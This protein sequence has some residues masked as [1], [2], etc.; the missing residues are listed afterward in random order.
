MRHYTELRTKLPAAVTAAIVVADLLVKSPVNR[1]QIVRE[2]N[3]AHSARTVYARIDY[4]RVKFV[5]VV[6]V[7]GQRALTRLEISANA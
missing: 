7:H 2:A 6:S 5:T 3:S 4:A 1:K